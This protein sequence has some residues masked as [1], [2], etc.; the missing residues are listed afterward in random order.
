MTEEE[1]QAELLEKN[2][3]CIPCELHKNMKLLSEEAQEKAHWDHL[4]MNPP[5]RLWEYMNGHLRDRITDQFKDEHLVRLID[6][7]LE[8]YGKPN[9]HRWRDD[10]TKEYNGWDKQKEW[11][12]LQP[13][14]ELKDK[15]IHV[16]DANYLDGM[17]VS[18]LAGGLVKFAVYEGSAAWVAL[19]KEEA[20][21]VA[22]F[23]LDIV[24]D[25]KRIT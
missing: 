13:Y 2:V 17:T 9:D 3:E 24:Y 7:V 6:W 5:Y 8:D 4:H 25:S 16:D 19:T 22:D 11:P 12:H 15:Q 21:R 23:L 18:L 1:F 14:S 20:K 10:P